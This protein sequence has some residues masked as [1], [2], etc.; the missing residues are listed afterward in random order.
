MQ[1]LI[2]T[3]DP[4]A[5][6]AMADVPEPTPSTS[7]LIVEVEAFSPNRGETF[8]LETPRPNWRPGKDIAGRV[9]QEAASGLGPALGSRVVAHSEEAGWAQR[10]AVPVSGATTLPDTLAFEVAAALPLAG[11][12]ALRLL[13]CAGPLSS[14]RILLTGASGGVGHYFVELAAR[15]GARVTAVTSSAARG[16]RLRELG[17]EAIVTTVADAHGT[18]DVVLDSV[19]GDSL[20][21]VLRKLV[22]LGQAIWFG[23][24]SRV[25][26]TLDF[27]DWD[28]PL[29]SA[30]TGSAT[31]GPAPRTPMTWPPW[32]TSSNA[33]TYTPKSARSTI[34]RRPPRSSTTWSTAKFVATRSSPSAGNDRV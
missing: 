10:A 20:M 29:A 13:R 33:A 30:S 25:P 8:L 3:G 28:V 4:G 9:V 18:F 16:E 14:R 7:Q 34:G 24:A 23:Q 27:F 11:L 12:T 6:V 31:N 19:G 22:P 32:Y 5:L 1:A 15:Q 21:A 26:P 17:A 2:P